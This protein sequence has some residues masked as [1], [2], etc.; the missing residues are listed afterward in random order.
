MLN[1]LFIPY[2]DTGLGEPDDFLELMTQ[3]FGYLK[4]FHEFGKENFIKYI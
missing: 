4:R 2:L 3:Y 1:I